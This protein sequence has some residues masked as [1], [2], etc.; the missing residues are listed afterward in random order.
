MIQKKVNKKTPPSTII[1][2]TLNP[3]EQVADSTGRHSKKSIDNRHQSQYDQHYMNHVCGNYGNKSEIYQ[4]GGSESRHSSHEC[5]ENRQERP[6]W[7]RS[8]HTGIQILTAGRQA[9]E[10]T[11]TTHW[12]NAWSTWIIR[13]NTPDQLRLAQPFDT[14]CWVN[15]YRLS[16]VGLNV[17]LETL[18]S[19]KK[20]IFPANQLTGAEHPA[21]SKNHMA[22]INKA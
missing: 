13:Y 6:T 9:E 11:H 16:W 8:R 1:L 22:D 14:H 2:L 3:P 12:C 5:T 10:W 19:L 21:F 18:R 17:W 20:T 15:I 7:R 4:S